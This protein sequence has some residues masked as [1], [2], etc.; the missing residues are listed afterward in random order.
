MTKIESFWLEFPWVEANRS[1]RKDGSGEG[2]GGEEQ[3]AE[4]TEIC[5]EFHDI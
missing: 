3:M 5:F 1:S 2:G 4:N